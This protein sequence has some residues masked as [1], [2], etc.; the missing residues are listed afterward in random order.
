MK[1]FTFLMLLSV[2]FVSPYAFAQVTSCPCD[3]EELPNGNSGDEIIGILCPG[4]SLAEGNLSVVDPNQVEIIRPGGEKLGLG[5]AVFDD[6]D[7]LVCSIFEETVGEEGFKLSDEEYEFCRTSLIAR[8]GLL[9]RNIPT[10][11][12]WGMI[13]MA[14]VL[15]MIGLYAASRRRKATA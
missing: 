1:S 6:G 14:G 11:S 5:Y 8:C 10:L 4:G 12:E 3:T 9:N 2:L 15:G 7:D 13:A